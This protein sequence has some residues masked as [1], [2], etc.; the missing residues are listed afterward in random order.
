MAALKAHFRVEASR[1][2]GKALAAM[3]DGTPQ[4]SSY[5]SEE[6]EPA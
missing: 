6:I 5:Q 2:F 4:I 1:A 3:A